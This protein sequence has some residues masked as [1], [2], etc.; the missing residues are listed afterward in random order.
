M[1]L[2]S[3]LRTGRRSPS[4]IS[5]A[6]VVVAAAL[7]VGWLALTSY[8]QAQFE[9]ELALATVTQTNEARVQGFEQFVLRTIETAD[10]ATRHIEANLHDLR[11]GLSLANE[12]V[13]KSAV[14]DAFV[15]HIEGEA[16]VRAG[17]FT[18][19]ETVAELDRIAAHGFRELEITPPLKL[20]NG[21]LKVA[22]LRRFDRGKGYVAVLMDPRRFT[23]FAQDIPFRKDDLI[24]LIGLD[25][26]T[27]ARRTGASLSA[28]EPVQG[29]VMDQQRANPN[30]TYVGPS[31]L[32]GIPRIFSHRRLSQ[33][34][35]FATSGTPVTVVRERTSQQRFFQ[36][37]AAI[38][39]ALA[40]AAA[41]I[42]I[43]VA[44]RRRYRRL[45][46]LEDSNAR[47]REAQ[48]IGEMGDWD[49]YPE[50]DRLYWSDSLRE[51]YGLAPDERIDTVAD[52]KIHIPDEDQE[53]VE[54]ELEKVLVDGETGMWE[55]NAILA[56][57]SRSPRRVVAV[58][59]R[60]ET[61]G[62][63]GVH[64]TDQ[65]ITHIVQAR[66]VERRLSELARF[67]SVNSLAATLAHELNQPLGV[68]ANYLGAASRL[69][70]E[71]RS[72]SKV[73]HYISASQE[74]VHHLSS[75]IDGARDLVTPEKIELEQVDLPDA[76]EN[77]M[78]LLRGHAG[79]V[80]NYKLEIAGNSSRIWSNAAQ[81]KQ[82]LFNLAKN[83][84]EAIPSDREPILSFRVSRSDGHGRARVDVVDNGAGIATI[85]DP[86]AAL[87]TTKETGLGLGLSLART[88][89]EAHGGKIW[90]EQTGPFGTTISFTM[91]ERR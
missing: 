51:M 9:K 10:L 79:R 53:K 63:V 47:L 28:G 1:V 56:D 45:V 50:S 67:D 15:V 12:P 71:G 24:S 22:A 76:I 49:Y 86:F 55:M 42:T 7:G 61:G 33:Y 81:V 88:I 13:L 44:N 59:I 78:T 18:S 85:D 29:L 14:F 17:A 36:G 6:L 20:A 91:G 77:V 2:N 11:D 70:E 34:G 65:D 16:P 83:S 82:V 40:I 68:T 32:D 69:L 60:D 66:N 35:I 62:I 48:R 5:E 84:L 46:E 73:A 19:S 52:V 30:G 43:I 87:N 80:F 4:R 37:M 74:Q 27:R 39:G 21:R 64:G 41:A 31:V 90:V 75:I 26:I 54:K 25:G 3:S 8:R 38:I 23:D 57:G 58:P 72:M 89:V